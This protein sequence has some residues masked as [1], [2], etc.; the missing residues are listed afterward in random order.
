M[1]STQIYSLCTN[2]YTTPCTL[3]RYIV[4]VQTSTQHHVLY[5]DI[6]LMYKPVHNTMYSTQIYSSCTNQYSNTMYSTQIYGSCTNQY[7]TPYTLPRYIV[8]YTN[9]CTTPC[10]LPRYIVHYT[11]QYTTPFTLPRY[12]VYIQTST[13]HYV[14]YLDI[15]F[16]YKPVHNTMYATQIYS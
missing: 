14:L 4:H 11:N 6:Q 3:P 8:H 12:I 13:P 9:Q 10:A 1:Y 5:L 2:Q 7:T 15:Q 16:I